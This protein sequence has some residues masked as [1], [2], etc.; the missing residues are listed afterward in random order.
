[1]KVKIKV[2]YDI[3]YEVS[4]K[5]YDGETDINKIKIIEQ[6]QI[7]STIQ[8]ITCNEVPTIEINVIP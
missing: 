6:E 2:M 5:D 3:E 7:N 1:M 4:P 8:E